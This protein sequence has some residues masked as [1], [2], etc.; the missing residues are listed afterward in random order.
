MKLAIP[1]FT[2]AEILVVGDVMLDRYWHGDVSRISPEAPVPIV[3]V[4]YAEDRAG[5]GANVASNITSLG[6]KATLLGIVGN[7]E[8]ATILE[9][10]LKQAQITSHLV[11]Y[12]NAPT[13][14]KL[15]VVGQQ[16]QLLRLDFE[17]EFGVSASARAALLQTYRRYLPSANLV[18]LSDYAKG[19]LSCSRELI[20]LAKERG[21]PILVD[22]KSKDFSAYSGATLITP[23]QHEFEAVVGKCHTDEELATKALQLI[24]QYD[25]S[26]IL[27]TRGAKGMSLIC[28]EENPLHIGTHAREV[29][30][31][32]GAGD[33]VIAMLGAA[34]AGGANLI[35]AVT[36]ANAAAGVVVGK[37][38]SAVV[39]LAE[40]RQ[41]L[42]QRQDSCATI[43]TQE[44]LL[45][46]VL[47]AKEHGE[48][49][50]MTNGC[51]DIIHAGHISYLEQAKSLGHRL[52]VAVNDDDSVKRLKGKDRPVNSLTSRMAVLA[53]LRAVD[54]VVPFSEDTPLRLI[55]KVLPEVLVKG[56][57]WAPSQIV[58][59]SEVTA[60]G[61]KVVTIAFEEGFSTTNTI[62]HIKN[63]S[64]AEL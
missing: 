58:G 43:L 32:S 12:E 53:A 47:E 37:A 57:D 13:I 29:Y 11:R 18:I 16:Q 63:L 54:W 7:D 62:K 60:A 15:R 6:G 46:Q 49:I 56:G 51:F 31:V 48:R 52:I 17:K 40:L 30:D 36:L 21:C 50:V 23:N 26:A 39:S 3:H 42:K 20:K 34:L 44:E 24:K 4:D 45:Q 8:N 25:F 14:I 10:K 2:R 38:G 1:N 22:P 28:K 9:N 5:G 55:T 19:T 59:A 41:A 35:D 61:G 64:T 27:V 33:T